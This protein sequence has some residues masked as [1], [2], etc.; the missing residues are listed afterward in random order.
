MLI[1]CGHDVNIISHMRYKCFGKNHVMDKNTKIIIRLVLLLLKK[2]REVYLI[3]KGE[4]RGNWANMQN[5]RPL[6]L[7]A[8]CGAGCL[9][10]SPN[11][12][13]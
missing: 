1:C 9:L 7:Y 2:E 10:G 3:S 11:L 13:I 8:L 6:A 4:G 5:Y 12:V